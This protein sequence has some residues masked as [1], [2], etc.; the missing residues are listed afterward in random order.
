MIINAYNLIKLLLCFYGTCQL[1]M[2]MILIHLFIHNDTA[3]LPHETLVS[4][5]YKNKFI[6]RLRL[7]LT[8][9]F[10]FPS[11]LVFEIIGCGL[12]FMEVFK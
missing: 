9:I 2:F 5:W 6:N 4:V 3:L 10:F 7:I 8:F 12:C 11:L 1:L